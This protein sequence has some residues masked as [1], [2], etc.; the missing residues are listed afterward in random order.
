MTINWEHFVEI[1][2]RMTDETNSLLLDRLQHIQIEQTP[3]E[4]HKD[5]LSI[6]ELK[7]YIQDQQQAP[8]NDIP[9]LPQMEYSDDE[10]SLWAAIISEYRQVVQKLPKYASIMI[11][12]GVPPA[13]RGK[14]WISMCEGYSKCFESLYDSL[15]AEWTPFVK[16]IGRDLNR[17]FPEIQLFQEKNGDGQLKLGRVLRAYSAYDMQVGYC[18]GLTFLAG[19]L[20]LHMSDKEAFCVLVKLMEDY[21]LRSMF[22]ADMNGLQLRMYQFESLLAKELPEL[23][24]HFEA[25]GVNTIYASQWFLSFFAVTC[26]LAMLVRIYDLMF[27]EG[28]IPTLMRVALAVLKRNSKILLAFDDEEQILSHLL[29]RQLW[30]AYGRDADL[31]VSDITSVDSEV[32]ECLESLERKW[33]GDSL[34]RAKSRSRR[35]TTSKKKNSTTST[36][37]SAGGSIASKIPFSL[38]TGSNNNSP[39]KTELTRSNSKISIGSDTTNESNESDFSLNEHVSSASSVTS[40][41]SHFDTKSSKQLQEVQCQLERTQLA[42]DAERRARQADKEAIENMLNELSIGGDDDDGKYNTVL[43][44]V[45]SRFGIIDD[46]V[47]PTETN[48][49]TCNSC[50]RYLMELAAVKTSE[51]IAR[52]EVDELKDQILQYDKQDTVKPKNASSWR[53]W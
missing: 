23:N 47:K 1:E 48:S 6:D 18:Q 33:K 25:H 8:Y 52:Q 31:M 49:S 13:L 10:L 37:T 3:K 20:L 19:P 41:E 26:P 16:I 22:T 35:N 29:G 42:L 38:W 2:S 30:D 24:A 9:N 40:F 43:S 15:A 21:N 28:A 11:W 53:M 32:L 4:C 7:E 27:A 45:K 14:A 5:L 50:E 51:A 46:S 36:T 34:T 17:T 44:N 39:T 12:S